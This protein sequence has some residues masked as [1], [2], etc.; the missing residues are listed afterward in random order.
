MSG[1]FV[2]RATNNLG[3]KGKNALL[4]HIDKDFDHRVCKLRTNL[5]AALFSKNY[6]SS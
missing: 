6:V 3:N 2:M 5:Y 1:F 4:R